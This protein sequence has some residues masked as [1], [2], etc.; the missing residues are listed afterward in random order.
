MRDPLYG[1]KRDV[2]SWGTC[3]Q[4]LPGGAIEWLIEH[5]RQRELFAAEGVTPVVRG[6]EEI[7]KSVSNQV[8]PTVWCSDGLPF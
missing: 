1:C 4:C 6:R 3:P 5:G 7:E 8:K 2:D